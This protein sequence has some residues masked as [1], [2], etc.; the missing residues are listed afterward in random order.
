MNR[1]L[2]TFVTLPLLTAWLLSS[3]PSFAHASGFSITKDMHAFA[4]FRDL[5]E[6]NEYDASGGRIR[7]IFTWTRP[8][9]IATDSAGNLYVAEDGGAV[10]R[11]PARRTTPDRQWTRGLLFPSEVA[12]DARGA[13]FVADHYPSTDGVIVVFENGRSAPSYTITDGIRGPAGLAVDPSGDLFVYNYD[14]STITEYLRGQSHVHRS[15]PTCPTSLGG[16]TFDAQGLM[17]VSDTCRGHGEISVYQAGADNPFEH[18]LVP[19]PTEITTT[20]NGAVLVVSHNGSRL[21]AFA[22]STLQ[23]L[24]SMTIRPRDYIYGLAATPAVP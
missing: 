9:G 14:A 2:A 1:R 23:P 21:S 8:E 6:V 7:Q 17:Y 24:G 20:T 13:L 4:S 10:V 15:L 3:G 5:E 22:Q 18:V 12:M 16:L 19:N 11:Y